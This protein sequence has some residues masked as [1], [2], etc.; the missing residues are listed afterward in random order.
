MCDLYYWMS[1]ISFRVC[2]PFLCGLIFSCESDLWLLNKDDVFPLNFLGLFSSFLFSLLVLHQLFFYLIIS[3]VWCC[4]VNTITLFPP[5]Y[6]ILTSWCEM[7]LFHYKMLAY[8][9]VGLLDSPFIIQL[10]RIFFF[11]KKKKEK[12]KKERILNKQG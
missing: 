6:S 10:L 11:L 8:Q 3:L 2:W 1:Y 5:R 12:W 4:I 7:Q 9:N